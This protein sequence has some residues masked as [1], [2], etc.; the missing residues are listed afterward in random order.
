M[1]NRAD[2]LETLVKRCGSFQKLCKSVTA[3]RHGDITERELTLMATGYAANRHP[4]LSFEQA[5]AKRYSD[6]RSSDEARAFWDACNVIKGLT[7]ARLE[8]EVTGGRRFINDDED[9]DALDELHAKAAKLRKVMPQLSEAQAFA[10]VYQDPNN[11]ELRRR[12]RAQ[13]GF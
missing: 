10:K 9:E 13:N 11:V 8:P 4:E 3:G 12:E 6:A 7:P 2:E 1:P 5:F